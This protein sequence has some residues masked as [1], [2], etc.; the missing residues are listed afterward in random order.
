MRYE[1]MGKTWWE[2]KWVTG[3]LIQGEST[4]FIVPPNLI[5]KHSEWRPY[6]VDPE[7]VRPV[8]EGDF[9]IKESKINEE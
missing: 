7:T 9:D 3:N 4:M 1:F 5:F 2:G 8:N 6:K